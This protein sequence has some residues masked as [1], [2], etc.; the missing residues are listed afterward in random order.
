MP[1]LRIP[2]IYARQEY[3]DA[4]EQ[5]LEIV[6][7]D[8]KFQDDV[9]RTRMLEIFEMAGDDEGLVTNYRSKLSSLLF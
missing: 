6:R 7:R 9:G 1:Q 8:R 5:L 4:C 2:A 3:A